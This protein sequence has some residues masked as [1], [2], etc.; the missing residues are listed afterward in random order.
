MKVNYP[1]T[2]TAADTVKRTITGT[3]VTWNEKG[4]T[5][6]GP[7]VFA[8][9]SIDVKPVKLLLEHDRTRPIGKM[10]KHTATES[11][12]EATFKIA[13]TM[14]GEDALVEAVEGLRDGFSVGAMINE[15]SNDNGVMKISSAVL[16]EVS[17]VTDP[18]IDSARVSEV[19]A[20][21]NEEKKD[22]D[23]ATVETEQPTEGEKVSDTTVSA[24]T[25]E[26]TVEATKSE[27]K[28]NAPVFSSQ[29][30]R[31]PVVDAAS[32][33]E[34]SVRATL[35]DENSK[36][37]IAAASDGTSTEWAGLVPTPQ[38]S[39]IINGKGT[40]A[41]PTIAAVSTAALPAAGLTFEI[42]RVKTMPTVGKSVAEKGAFSDTQGEIE[43]LSVSVKKAA[44]MQ[45]FDVEVLDRT[46]PS[47]FTELL[48]LMAEAYAAS[49]DEAMYDALIN[50]GTLDSTTITQP[51]DGDELAG[52]VSRA[53]TSIYKNTKRYP[54]GIVMSP[55]Q[56]G[57][58][59]GLTDSSKRNIFNVAGSPSNPTGQ[60]T[61]TDAVGNIYGLPV[62]VTPN[63]G[64]TDGD[65][66]VIVVSR[67]TY[68][69]YESAAPLQLRTNIV[70]TGQV[71]VGIYGYYA[72]APKLAEG[73]FR[74]NNA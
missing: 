62:Y 5:S 50:N 47:F 2:I 26:E 38:L 29:R 57:K 45:K 32:Y 72:I 7:T 70:A 69:F 17:L 11:G 30:V 68:T 73:A 3:I 58:F 55:D 24:P 34:H 23:S 19:A 14:S 56:W 1:I 61:P 59:V 42:P 22:S 15:W 4:N 48:S 10:I 33:L 65:S 27:V 28:A 71:E 53:A 13:N 66:S 9:N 39:Q 6:V 49:T 12:I 8:E 41:R 16:D 52:F 31:T 20:S 35:G 36:L 54:T 63:S 25:V 46:S 21:E 74:F 44:G 37:Y 64:L 40:I 67:D 51:W 18:A 43:Y 60:L